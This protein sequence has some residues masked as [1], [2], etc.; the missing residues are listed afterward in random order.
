MDQS[1]ILPKLKEVVRHSAIYGVGSVLQTLVGF[2]LIPLYTKHYTTDIYG[3]F[4]LLT[5]CG[6]LAGAI[7]Y[8]GGSSAL[9]RFYYEYPDADGRRKVIGNCFTITI[10]GACIQILLGVLFC[11][12]ISGWLFDSQR[13]ALHVA[14]VLGSYSIMFINGYFLLLLRFARKSL[15]VVAINLVGFVSGIAFIVYFLLGLKLGVLAPV[16]G[17]LCN[18]LLLCALLYW[19]TR[20]DVCLQVTRSELIP[21]LKY[22]LPIVL[23]GLA[24]YLLAWTDRLLLKHFA[25]MSDVGIYSLGY[26]LG[27]SINILLIIPF[28]Q[29]WAPMRMQYRNDVLV[30]QLYKK[31][32]TYYFV[33]GVVITAGVGVFSNEIVVVLARNT[34]YRAAAGVIPLI[35]LAYL[36]FGSVNI[37]DVGIAISRR[38]MWHVYIYGVCIVV[39]AVLNMAL[40][41]R[42]GALGAA[43]TALATFGLLVVLVFLV[44][45]HFFRLEVEFGRLGRLLLGVLMVLG[46]SQ[47][48]PSVSLAAITVKCGLMLCLLGFIGTWVLSADEREKLAG[49]IRGLALRVG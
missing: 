39:N 33:I 17:D 13:Y 49:I 34:D 30:L 48:I 38:T 32:L 35:M 22:G 11:R 41:S 4:S 42:Y 20:E 23:A 31:V 21:Q 15:Q 18:Q 43:W 36:L 26:R 16:L 2:I 5:L 6:T 7:F 40:I 28:S 37:I 44:S 19:V 27:T 46:I 29:I 3:V 45:N 12:Q 10:V 47:Q 14:V 8:L 25:T 24:Y 1:S 9:S